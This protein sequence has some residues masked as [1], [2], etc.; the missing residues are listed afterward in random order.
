MGHYLETMNPE[1]V[2][3][4]DTAPPRP[5]GVGT[6]LVYIARPGEGRAMKTEF[7]AFV[8]HVNESGSLSLLVFY[9]EDDIQMRER[10]PRADDEFP[11]GPCWRFPEGA[12]PERFEPSRLNKIRDDLNRLADTVWGDYEPVEGGMIGVV[13]LFEQKLTAMQQQIDAMTAAGN[14]VKAV[15]EK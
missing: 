6:P 14:G 11:E 9:A 1:A 10:V 7:S 12:E 13:R 3:N 8:T 15:R 5:P 4:I 2:D